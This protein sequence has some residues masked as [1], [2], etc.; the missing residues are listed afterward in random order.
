MP[1][2][3]NDNFNNPGGY[4][5]GNK[6]IFTYWTTFTRENSNKWDLFAEKPTPLKGHPIEVWEFKTNIPPENLGVFWDEARVKRFLYQMY[7]IYYGRQN[8]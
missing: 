6:R 2:P 4:A 3:Q 5:V 7:D 8:K 1:K